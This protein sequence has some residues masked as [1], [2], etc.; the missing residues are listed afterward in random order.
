M[1]KIVNI[2]IL[3]NMALMSFIMFATDPILVS[4]M[5]FD[6]CMILSFKMLLMII[7]PGL[8][9]YASTFTLLLPDSSFKLTTPKAISNSAS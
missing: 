7:S 1:A 6:T 4:V 5:M 2:F 3:F 9:G 8:N